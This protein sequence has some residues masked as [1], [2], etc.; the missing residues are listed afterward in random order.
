MKELLSAILK[1][2]WLSTGEKL[3]LGEV[4]R[5]WGDVEGSLGSARKQPEGSNQREAA[6][7]LLRLC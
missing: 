6:R 2:K 4:G 5:D 7:G 1:D 3:G